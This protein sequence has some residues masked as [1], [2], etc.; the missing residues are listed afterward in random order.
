M[1]AKKPETEW[2][3]VDLP[4]VDYTEVWKLQG[5]LVAARKEGDL[6]KNLVLLLEHPPVFT[7]GRRGELGHLTVSEDFLKAAGISIIRVEFE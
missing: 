6:D 7:L 2:F 3:C 1:M 5:N 4:A